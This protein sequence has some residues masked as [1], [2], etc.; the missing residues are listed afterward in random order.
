MAEM[1]DVQRNSINMLNHLVVLTQEI[2]AHRNNRVYLE[3]AFMDL[4]NN[5]AQ[6]AVDFSAQTRVTGMMRTL[7]KYRMITIKRERLQFVYEQ[8][9]A[10]AMR[11]AIPS[12]GSVMNTILSF[13][14]AKIVGS[15]VYMAVDSVNSYAASSAAADMQ[16]IQSGWE[17]DDAADDE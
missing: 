6:D 9:Q 12:A 2:H 10:Q 17:L 1:T 14:P 15:L 7:N 13:D 4:L 11:N 3:Q 16:F 5:T 8:N